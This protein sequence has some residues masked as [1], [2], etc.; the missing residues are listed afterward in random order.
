MNEVSLRLSAGQV[1]AV[2]TVVE[3][4][5]I[6]IGL[7][8]LPPLIEKLLVLWNLEKNGENQPDIHPKINAS[9]KWVN[10]ILPVLLTVCV[11]LV[12]SN[13]EERQEFSTRQINSTEWVLMDEKT[14]NL[15]SVAPIISSDIRIDNLAINAARKL[16]CQYG[17]ESISFGKLGKGVS[18]VAPYSFP[19]CLSAASSKIATMFHRKFSQLEYV[20]NSTALKSIGFDYAALPNESW[21]V[22]FPYPTN[23]FNFSYEDF[24]TDESQHE[25]CEKQNFSQ[26]TKFLFLTAGPNPFFFYD[27][28]IFQ[29]SL[30]I[31]NVLCQLQKTVSFEHD[32]ESVDQLRKCFRKMSNTTFSGQSTIK[33]ELDHACIYRSIPNPIADVQSVRL[34]GLSSISSFEAEVGTACTDAIVEYTFIRFPENVIHNKLS[35]K[36]VILPFSFEVVSGDCEVVYDELGLHST[37]FSAHSEWISSESEKLKGLNYKQKYYAFMMQIARND[38]Q[39]SIVF[40]NAQKRANK[41]FFI[42]EDRTYIDTGV[43]FSFMLLI[44]IV[45]LL[46]AL[47]NFIIFLC[48]PARL[49]KHNFFSDMPTSSYEIE[50]DD[51]FSAIQEEDNHFGQV[52]STS[53]S[54]SNA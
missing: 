45:C 52:N 49:R 13:L 2:F 43:S 6:T 46:V 42:S 9:I 31:F 5:I 28:N 32:E 40:S 24:N 44:F 3:L 4:I 12:E 16:S 7:Y 21:F 34:S 11:A 15:T 26:L 25:G 17:L 20:T 50:I 19:N 27:S 54:Q 39:Y 29:F 23:D 1:S 38:F 22:I 30:S 35:N 18:F 51:V 33:E 8:F 48:L 10:I 14:R 41:S 37:V 47:S 36:T 53:V